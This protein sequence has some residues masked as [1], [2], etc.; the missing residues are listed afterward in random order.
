MATLKPLRCSTA[1]FASYISCKDAMKQLSEAGLYLPSK[2]SGPIYFT[3]DIAS[4]TSKINLLAW[5]QYGAG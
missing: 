1:V 4:F 2:N 5:Y 3:G